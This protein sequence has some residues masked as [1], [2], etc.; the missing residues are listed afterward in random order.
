MA[1]FSVDQVPSEVLLHALE[2]RGVLASSSS[3]C[4]SRR[5]KPPPSLRHAGLKSNQGAVRFSL[6]TNT[7]LEEI[8]S[9]IKAFIEVVGAIRSGHAGEL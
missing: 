7:S 2:M 1:V 5:K 6:T 9:A 3:A 4:H 8:E